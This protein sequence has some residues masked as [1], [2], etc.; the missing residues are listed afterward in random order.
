MKFK[1]RRHLN[2]IEVKSS[3]RTESHEPKVKVFVPMYL[4]IRIESYKKCKNVIAKPKELI[5]IVMENQK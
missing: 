4:P 2:R 3:L 1:A 5:R